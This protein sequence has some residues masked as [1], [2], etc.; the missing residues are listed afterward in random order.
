MA[1]AKTRALA[2]IGAVAGLCPVTEPNL[3]DGLWRAAASGGAQALGAAAGSRAPADS[4]VLDVEQPSLVGRSGAALADALV[5]SSGREAIAGV[6][7]RGVRV[8]ERGR[9]VNE[10]GS[11]DDTDT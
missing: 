9:H 11:P 10:S 6:W 2:T 4:V 1:E 8:I 7:R 5:F 3:G